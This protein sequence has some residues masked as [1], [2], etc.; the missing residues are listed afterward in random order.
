[1]RSGFFPSFISILDGL[2]SARKTVG[3]VGEVDSGLWPAGVRQREE[4]VKDEGQEQDNQDAEKGDVLEMVNDLLRR[5]LLRLVGSEIV[6]VE[7]SVSLEKV[8]LFSPPQKVPGIHRD[9]Q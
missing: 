1:V 2:D 6:L 7:S 3:G 9:W 5:R 8:H 4:L